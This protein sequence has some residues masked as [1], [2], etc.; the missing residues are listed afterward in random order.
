MDIDGLEAL[1]RRIEQQQVQIICRDL[2]SPSSLAQAILNARPYAFLDDAPAE[3]RRTLAVQQQ[4]YTNPQQAAD[5]ALLDL[6]AINRVQQEAW[7][8]PRTHDELHDALVVLG[9]LTDNEMQS[10][11]QGNPTILSALLQEQ[12]VTQCI[13]PNYK[14][15]W[16]AAERWG[17]MQLVHPT[18][19]AEPKLPVVQD[20]KTATCIREDALRELTRSRLEGVGPVTMQ[21]LADELAV[22]VDDI[23]QVLLALENEGFVVRGQFTQQHSLE[24]CERR[25]LARIHHYTIKSLRK[26]INPVSSAAF[27]QFLFHWQHLDDKL[28]SKD[29]LLTIIEQLEGFSIPAS[30]WESDILPTRMSFYLPDWLDNLCSSGRVNWM[31]IN[32]MLPSNTEDGK[33][34]QTPIS[35]TPISLMPRSSVFAWQLEKP[36]EPL[37]L[38]SAT[39]TLYQLLHRK[40]ALFFTDLVH[41]SGLLASQ[42]ETGLAQLVANGLVTADSFIG[43][44]SLVTPAQRRPGFGQRRRMNSN[45]LNI[46]DAGR[47]T[48]IETPAPGPELHEQRTQ[49]IAKTLLLRY[50]IVF[51][52]LLER[53]TVAP[54]WRELLYVYRRMEARGEIR[55]GRFVEGFSGEQFALP[56]AVSLIRKFTSPSSDMFVISAVDPLNLTGIIT[57]GERVARN[58]KVKILYQLGKPVALARAGQFEFLSEL[59]PQA[60]WQARELLLRK[61][62]SAAFMPVPTEV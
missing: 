5:S 19:H 29:A 36:P 18:H 51:R 57:P 27:M 46:E 9:F 30:A 49:H 1:L 13:A 15:L 45:A 52:A 10:M 40:G 22:T 7:P 42:V 43:L 32:S 44:R 11:I 25:L 24:W 62:R 2:T 48:L 37:A 56:E 28:E 35:I 59:S 60:Q 58:N 6:S 54:S 33:A 20:I 50:G 23:Q 17:E 34:R 39:Q 55:G 31:R 41:S 38:S 3:E 61:N 53:E 4:R 47:W 12:R 16:V 26:Q 8:Q 14:A 21:K